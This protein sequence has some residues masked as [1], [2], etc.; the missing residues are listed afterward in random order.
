MIKTFD[1][2]NSTSVNE[3]LSAKVYVVTEFGKQGN[4]TFAKPIGVYSSLELAQTR[5]N[6]CFEATMSAIEETNSIISHEQDSMETTIL[7]QGGKHIVS[8]DECDMDMDMNNF[9]FIETK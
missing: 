6:T 2:F 4:D 1:Q 5:M 7:F 3:G 8:I 9:G